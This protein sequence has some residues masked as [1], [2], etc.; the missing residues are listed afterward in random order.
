MNSESTSI[1]N[2][3]F[4]RK[5]SRFFPKYGIGLLKLRNRRQ[6]YCPTIGSADAH[7]QPCGVSHTDSDFRVKA[8]ST[9]LTARKRLLSRLLK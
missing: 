6:C 5:K 9:R 8:I 2:T 4:V 3:R 7:R 1:E